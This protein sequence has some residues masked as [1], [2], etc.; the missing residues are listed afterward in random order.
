MAT[1]PDSCSV[2]P[3]QTS[4]YH[5]NYLDI[6]PDLLMR[7][8]R[9]FC[10]CVIVTGQNFRLVEMNWADC[11]GIWRALRCSQRMNFA[12]LDSEFPSLPILRS[13]YR[14]CRRYPTKRCADHRAICWICSDWGC[15]SSWF[16]W[17]K[18]FLCLTPATRS[19]LEELLL[20]T[21]NHN[22]Y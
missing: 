11:H 16:Y 14:L 17:T 4:T 2:H 6:T 15:K 20:L 13:K 7:N 18:A 5:N 22:S 8:I 12:Y 10:V 9:A 19:R 21:F 3:A 1:L